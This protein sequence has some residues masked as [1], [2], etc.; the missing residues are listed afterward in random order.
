MCFILIVH[1]ISTFSLITCISPSGM[2]KN[3]GRQSSEEVYLYTSRE[4]CCHNNQVEYDS[5]MDKST[6]EMGQHSSPVGNV[7]YPD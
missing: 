3:D 6:D 2:C 7:Y 5:C 1:I 4:D